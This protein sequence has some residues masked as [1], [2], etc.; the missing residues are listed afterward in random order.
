MRNIKIFKL[1]LISILA[2]T[3]GAC[4]KEEDPASIIQSFEPYTPA[5][6]ATTPAVT[7]NEEEG[8]TYTFHFTLDDRQVTDVHMA[9]AVGPST[10]AEEGVDF[11]L[12]THEV[13][14]PALGGQEG[15]DVELV[16]YPDYD[17]EDQE[18]IFLTFSTETPT[19]VDDTETLVVTLEDAPICEYDFAT[20]VGEAGGIDIT[21]DLIPQDP[22]PSEVVISG[23]PGAF[24]I[25]G[26][27]VGWMTDFWGEVITNMEAVDMEVVDFNDYVAEVTIPNQVYMSTTYNG[28][29]QEAYTIEGTGILTKC[30]K[31]LVIEYTLS[32]YGYDWAAYSHDEGY[33]TEEKFT[34]VLTL[35]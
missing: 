13:D 19:G 12:L 32:N 5:L 8:E 24:K 1:L 20:I 23:T 27:G 16:I 14:F 31:T 25:T 11:D 18:E 34:A 4:D 26:L 2:L 35:P 30:T 15:F 10:T 6:D 7:A 33:M 29:P 3:I 17:L 28:A 21:M 22:Y 9:I